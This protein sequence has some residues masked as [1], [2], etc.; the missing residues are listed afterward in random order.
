MVGTLRDIF[1]KISLGALI[2]KYKCVE[3]NLNHVVED[4]VRLHIAETKTMNDETLQQIEQRFSAKIEG[5][6]SN[7][8]RIEQMVS[9][10]AGQ[11]SN[12]AS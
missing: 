9:G 8:V 12:A 3:A 5:L 2:L 6:Q 4:A 7:M 10:A 11:G 1:F